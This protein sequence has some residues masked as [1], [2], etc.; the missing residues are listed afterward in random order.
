MSVLASPGTGSPIWWTSCARPHVRSVIFGA[1]GSGTVKNSAFGASRILDVDLGEARG[2]RLAAG[3]ERAPE[4]DRRVQHRP[5]VDEVVLAEAVDDDAH[6]AVEGVPVGGA[7][8]EALAEEQ[9][10]GHALTTVGVA[11][12]QRD[13][14]A[15]VPRLDDVHRRRV[16][17]RGAPARRLERRGDLRV[18]ARLRVDH[19]EFV[20]PGDRPRGC[21]TT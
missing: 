7:V 3:R 15:V 4:V 10:V 18:P 5:R 14:D 12:H 1:L 13:V 20:H 8:L 17:D 6:D 11:A 9:D 19:A 21:S 16:R 2:A